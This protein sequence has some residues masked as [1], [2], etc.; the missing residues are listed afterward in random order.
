MVL[1]WDLKNNQGL[2]TQDHDPDSIEL[3][4]S[5]ALSYANSRVG[6]ETF[7]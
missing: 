6:G 4:A 2:F 3:P 1:G 7:C 5:G